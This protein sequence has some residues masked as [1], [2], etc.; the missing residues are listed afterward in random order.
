MNI[1]GYDFVS[2][3]Q[4]LMNNQNYRQIAHDLKAKGQYKLIKVDGNPYLERY[5]FLNLRPFSRIVIHR[6]YQSDSD[7]LHDHPWPFQ[8]FILEGGY[9][10]HTTEGRY[11]RPPGYTAQATESFLHR[12]ELDF[13]R[14]GPEVWTLFCMGPKLKDWG[15]IDEQGNWIR[16]DQ[17]L[18]EKGQ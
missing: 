11:W 9:Y 10:E 17:Y 15:F 18:S 2:L 3:G 8:N 13:D 1:S 4:E 7:G 5:Y 12:V 6:F 16:H 14:S